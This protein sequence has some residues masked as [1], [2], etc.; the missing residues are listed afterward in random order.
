MNEENTSIQEFDLQLI[1][2]YFAN[3]ERQGPGSPEITIK[4][5]SF[6]TNQRHEAE[7]YRKYKDYYCYVF[8]IGKKI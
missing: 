5:L 7:L 6:I 8:Y 3:L 4:T 1:V 2:D